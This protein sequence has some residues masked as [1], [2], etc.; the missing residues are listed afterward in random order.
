MSSVRKAGAPR[1][2]AYRNPD[3][4]SDPE[5]WGPAETLPP[6]IPGDSQAAR[7]QRPRGGRAVAAF[8]V[9][10][11][12][13]LAAAWA[14]AGWLRADVTT[15]IP[16][17]V[18]AI[19]LDVDTAPVAVR[20]GDVAQ[21]Q[22]V[23]HK[24]PLGA[25][26]EYRFVDGQLEVSHD[27]GI[28]F[29]PGLRQLEIVL[30]DA[31]RAG[32]PN[33]TVGT[34]TG[35]V[36]LEGD[37]GAVAVTTSTGKI[38]IAGTSESLRTEA[39]TGSVEVAGVSHEVTVETS[40]GSVNLDLRDV[41]SV[42]TRS[43]TGSQDIGVAGP[44]PELVESRTSTGGIEITLPDGTYQVHAKSNTGRTEVTVPNNSTSAHRVSAESSTGA[45]RI[46]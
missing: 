9:G 6:A 39:S 35:S 46:D 40:T 5:P 15:P 45:I 24:R 11:T 3:D 8:L 31:M 28:R 23:E 36:D 27:P 22:I 4:P 2:E 30:P 38:D 34:T 13:L 44:Q 25:E 33:V 43:A 1:W 37:Y 42:R 29:G 14:G 16:D 10:G 32:T 12:V 41:R 21:V 7:S 20:Y 18:Q 26:L 19:A 17:P